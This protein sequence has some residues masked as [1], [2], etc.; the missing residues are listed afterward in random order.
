MKNRKDIDSLERLKFRRK[1]ILVF[2]VCVLVSL[3]LYAILKPDPEE[4]E[5]NKIKGMI[6]DRS[7]GRMS[8]GDRESIRKMMDKLSPETRQRLAREVMRGMLER[9]RKKT[10][11]MTMEEKKLKVDEA[12]RKMRE[13]FV[14]MT[15]ERR[16]KAIERMNSPKAKKRM[17]AALG[18][19]YSD[20][21]PEERSLLDPV[22]REWTIEMNVLQRRGR[23]K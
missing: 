16:Q 6:L 11:G 8:R 7:R 12:V 9:F 21:S 14:K 1:A 15:D 18:F 4:R 17:K 19:Y 3:I 13:R 20:F 22:V 10:A 2:T 5:I 23:K